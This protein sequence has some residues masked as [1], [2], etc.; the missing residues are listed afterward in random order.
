MGDIP[1]TSKSTD[2]KLAA[3]KEWK[4]DLEKRL[5][6]RLAKKPEF[7]P[8]NKVN[9]GSKNELLISGKTTVEVVERSSGAWVVLRNGIRM[10]IFFGDD[11]HLRAS[12]YAN[13]LL[14]EPLDPP[15]PPPA[16]FHS[17]M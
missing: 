1:V 9:R 2:E 8:L 16:D 14:N 7:K 12:S 11:A 5:Q 4:E 3:F 17:L 10:N 6:A 13:K 15:F